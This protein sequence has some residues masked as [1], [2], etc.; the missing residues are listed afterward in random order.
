[1]RRNE[2]VGVI[3]SLLFMSSV[4]G[5][6]P[7][8]ARTIPVKVSNDSPQPRP[9]H[10]GSIAH[11]VKLT[12]VAD[13]GMGMIYSLAFSPDDKVLAAAGSDSQS[14]LMVA[15]PTPPLINRDLFAP[16]GPVEPTASPVVN[17]KWNVGTLRLWDSSKGNLLPTFRLRVVTPPPPSIPSYQGAIHAVAFSPD[18][19]ILATGGFKESVKLWEYPTQKLLLDTEQQGDIISFSPDG[20]FVAFLSGWQWAKSNAPG[21]TLLRRS[22]RTIKLWNV[23]TRKGREIRVSTGYDGISGLAWAP[24]SRRMVCL[25]AEYLKMIDTRTGKIMWQRRAAGSQSGTLAFSPDGKTIAVTAGQ[26]NTKSVVQ[27]WNAASGTMTKELRGHTNDIPVIRFSPDGRIL[28]SGSRD[29]LVRLW[30]VSSGRLL[31]TKTDAG[32]IFA[33]AF[34]H[35]GERLAIG[36]NLQIVLLEDVHRLPRATQ[37]GNTPS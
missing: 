9:V 26:T 17:V 37:R 15:T 30:Q 3:F 18:G 5:C 28:A 24:D 23:K 6:T 31:D 25:A 29:G 14:R 32:Q 20:V 12:H 19:Q 35:D 11:R 21:Y 4:A 13:A 10:R 27:L 8:G 7:Q 1:M 33:L 16:D 22:D 34:S 2:R 36:G